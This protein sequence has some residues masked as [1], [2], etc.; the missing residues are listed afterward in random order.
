MQ[1]AA[2]RRVERRH[3]SS[4][5]GAVRRRSGG[6]T[7]RH[8]CPP[9]TRELT[10]FAPLP[11]GPSRTCPQI[12]VQVAEDT[13]NI[14]ITMLAANEDEVQAYVDH[15]NGRW[16]NAF[17]NVLRRSA[18]CDAVPGWLAAAVARGTVQTVPIRWTPRFGRAGV[19]G[20]TAYVAAYV[21]SR[22]SRTSSTPGLDTAFPT[23]K[24]RAS[25]HLPTELRES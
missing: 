16:I 24:S 14:P 2:R 15:R 11:P 25:C 22:G 9:G 13:H 7:S 5:S 23:S 3:A 19:D 10:T 6:A 17:W 1:R 8:K 18:S 21:K 12:A 20:G 4:L